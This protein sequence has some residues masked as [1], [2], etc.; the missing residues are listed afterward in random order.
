VK[1]IANVDYAQMEQDRR[2]CFRNREADKGA[3]KG[4][5]DPLPLSRTLSQKAIASAVVSLSP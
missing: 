3:G 1:E 5:I 2:H 4:C